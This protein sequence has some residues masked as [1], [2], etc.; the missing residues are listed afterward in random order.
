MGNEWQGYVKWLLVDMKNIVATDIK[1]H[2]EYKPAPH[3][4]D[5]FCEDTGAKTDKKYLVWVTRDECEKMDQESINML[6]PLL[7]ALADSFE[8]RANLKYQYN[9][10]AFE[11]MRNAQRAGRFVVREWMGMS[12]EKPLVQMVAYAEALKGLRKAGELPP[13]E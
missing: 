4:C 9:R 2:S 6:F 11:A 7:V 3:D 1:N 10:E 12:V 13:I 8:E 5:V